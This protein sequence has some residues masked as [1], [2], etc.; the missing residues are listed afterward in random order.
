MVL[1]ILVTGGLLYTKKL[2]KSDWQKIRSIV[3]QKTINFDDSVITDFVKKI[4]TL[5]T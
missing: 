3:E 4:S 2:S 5:P 1:N